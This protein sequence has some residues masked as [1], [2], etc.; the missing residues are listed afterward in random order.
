MNIYMKY[1]SIN[2]L[3]NFHLHDA[4]VEKIEIKEKDM[5]WIL[6]YANVTVENSQNNNENDMCTEEMKITFENA[7]IKDFIWCGSESRDENG[8][9]IS[10]KEDIAIEDKDAI[11]ELKKTLKT[12]CC[13][14]GHRALE[15]QEQYSYIFTLN[16]NEGVC[17]FILVF[18]NVIA[19]WDKYNGDAW[20]VNKGEK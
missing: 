16:C 8:N 1:K 4:V 5:I 2:E 17:D 13:V 18:K 6:E 3:D 14:F 10:K 20:Y 7:V 15:N 11:K 19:E 9:L 12:A